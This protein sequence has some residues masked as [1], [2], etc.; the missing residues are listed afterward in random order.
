MIHNALPIARRQM[1]GAAAFKIPLG[2]G[3]DTDLAG[4]AQP[5]LVARRCK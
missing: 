4:S 2:I 3:F 1:N 5:H